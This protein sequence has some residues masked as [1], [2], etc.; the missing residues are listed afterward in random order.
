MQAPE[1]AARDRILATA[2]TLFYRDGLRATGID[3]LI[4]ESG[5]AKLTFY[6]H[7][8]SKEALVQAFL[9][10]RHEHWMAWFVDALERHGG[11]T[12][13]DLRALADVLAE[14]FEREAFRGCAFINAAAEPASP[15][16]LAQARE[17]KDEMRAAIARWLA[18]GTAARS[19]A[20]VAALA[21]DG[22]IVQAQMAKDDA[23]RE[24]VVRTLRRLL[25]DLQRGATQRIA[26]TGGAR[27]RSP[28]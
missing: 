21:F 28:T 7:F 18:G 25:G 15:E 11:K 8:P 5:V 6:R 19:L 3:R 13:H 4:K 2:L 12:P 27:R 17:H 23:A 26:G 10:L 24:D 1:S 20:E 14:W 22:A 16:A 9:S